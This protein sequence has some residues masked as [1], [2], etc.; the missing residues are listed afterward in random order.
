MNS[1]KNLADKLMSGYLNALNHPNQTK[2]C[3]VGFD[4]VTD[5]IVTAVKTRENHEVYTPFLTIADFGKKITAA[6]GKSGN[7]ELIVQRQKIGGNGP[8]LADALLK[9][10]HHLTLAGTIGLP[11]AI[12]PIFQELVSRCRAVIPLGPSAHSDAIE[13]EDGKIILGK[14]ENLNAV[15]YHSLI[16]QLGKSRLIDLMETTDLF[17]SANW[18]MLPQMNDLWHKLLAE[19]IPTISPKKRWLFVDLADPAKR[20]DEDLREALKLL[21]LFGKTFIVIQGLNESEALRM[22]STLAVPFKSNPDWKAMAKAIREKS[23]LTE[24]VI[25][26]TDFALSSSVAGEIL[27]EGPYTPK[28][29][30]TTGA[31]DNF[32]AGF[33][34]ALLYGLS[35]EEAL[36]SGVATSGFYVRTGHS[37]SM[38]E[39][40]HFLNAWA[41]DS[42]DN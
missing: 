5:D 21:K 8:I 17:I 15:S 16:D 36:L 26:G 22:A 29:F 38:E 4:G 12:E 19:I 39:L 1:L 20:T 2:Q 14:L 35:P 28:P 27:V 9:G 23:G 6:Q 13:F 30:L 10:G 40:K 25:H 41:E 31:G 33:C 42:L 11:G 3:F 34:N 32:N 18:T 7:I 24:V 37:P